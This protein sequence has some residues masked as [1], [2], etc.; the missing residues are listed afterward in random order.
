MRVPSLVLL[1]LS[2]VVAPAAELA[3][4]WDVEVVADSQ[5][6]VAKFRFT[7]EDGKMSG[8][9][10]ARG[11]EMPMKAV[12]AENDTVTFEVQADDVAV[13]FTVKITDTAMDGKWEA[14]GNSGSLKGKKQP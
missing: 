3:G 14:D 6:H 13:T 8:M 10:S 1:F 4:T 2:A 7:A 9:V 12:K 11:R 5:T